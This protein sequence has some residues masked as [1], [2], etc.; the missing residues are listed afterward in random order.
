M[1]VRGLKIPTLPLS[2]LSTHSL[3]LSVGV[4]VSFV[5]MWLKRDDWM[6]WDSRAELFLLP[7]SLASFKTCISSI[8]DTMSSKIII[9][10]KYIF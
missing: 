4:N 5:Q 9:F 3:A 7:I 6:I 8:L 2:T 1:R 10:S